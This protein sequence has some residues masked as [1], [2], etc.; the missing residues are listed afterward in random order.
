MKIKQFIPTPIDQHWII[1]SLGLIYIDLQIQVFLW[2]CVL[3]SLPEESNPWVINIGVSL[4]LL[5]LPGRLFPVF[6]PFYTLCQ[7]CF[8]VLVAP[9]PPQNFT[10]SVVLLQPLWWVCSITV[11]ICTTLAMTDEVE[12]LLCAS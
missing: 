5:E 4:I 12:P 1:S 3:I 8:R 11:L 6:V 9:H 7:Q 10:F 2:M